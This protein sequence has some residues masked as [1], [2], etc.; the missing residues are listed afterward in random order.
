MEEMREDAPRERREMPNAPDAE[1]AILGSMMMDNKAILDAMEI[2]SPDDFYN[3][4]HALMYESILELN[5]EGAEIDGV[6]LQDRMRQ[7]GAVPEVANLEFITRILESVAISSNAKEYAHIIKEKS[8]LRQIIRVSREAEEQAIS[9][10]DN[11]ENVIGVMEKNVF[12]LAQDEGKQD[13]TPIN[14]IVMNTLKKIHDAYKNGQGGVTGVP[15]GFLDLDYK[16]AGLQPADM[17]LI[18]A[19]PSMGKTALALNIAQH[20]AFHEHL[21]VAIFSLEMPK[22]ALVNRM[23]SMEA[24]IDANSLRVGKLKDMEWTELIHTGGMISESNL[25][26]DDKT[27]ITLSYFA[28]R[29]RKFKMQHPDLALVIIDYLQLM[30][31]SGKSDSRQQEV[32]DISR[33]IKQVAREINAPI[34]A[35]SQLSRAPE[36]RPDHRPMLSDLRESGAIEQDADVV[37]FIYRDDYYHPDTDEKNVSEINIAKQRNGA[38]GTV[39]LAWLPEYTKFGNLERNPKNLP[40]E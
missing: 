14:I 3:K 17:I 15:T 28:S 36:Q 38:V 34:I 20:V 6:T 24:H 26:I 27:G 16:L 25:M 29:C 23:I 7:K 40:P 32:S 30:Q 2:L 11:A 8:K 18:A 35:L 19:R 13:I 10:V 1:R 12:A 33:G 37:M 5:N 9:G 21:P 22:E 39:K 4:A 31:G